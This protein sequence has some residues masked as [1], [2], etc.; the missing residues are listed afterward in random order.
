MSTFPLT[1]YSIIYYG[2]FLLVKKTNQ[3]S[4]SFFP[5]ESIL[6]KCT[7]KSNFI[8][9]LPF[10]SEKRNY[11]SSEHRNYRFYFPYYVP[12]WNI[13]A[14]KLLDESNKE[15]TQQRPTESEMEQKSQIT[16]RN[17][18]THFSGEC[19]RNSPITRKRNYIKCGSFFS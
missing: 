5:P 1:V 19:I 16:L 13:T 8:M 14:T 15:T 10:T 7:L 17:N 9:F 2:R 3:R 4:W 6:T 12:T 18:A 11:C